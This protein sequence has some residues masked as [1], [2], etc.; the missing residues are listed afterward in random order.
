MRTYD[1]YARTN[2]PISLH[3]TGYMWHAPLQ[4]LKQCILDTD[5]ADNAAISNGS[6][7]SK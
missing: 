6:P 7:E 3:S 1:F 4:S 5:K 2:D